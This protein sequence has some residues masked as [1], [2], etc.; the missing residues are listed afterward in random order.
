MTKDFRLGNYVHKYER[1]T[2]RGKIQCK[3]GMSEY[4]GFNTHGYELMVS[5]TMWVSHTTDFRYPQ[6]KKFLEDWVWKLFVLETVSVH[7]YPDRP[8]YPDCP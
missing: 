1:H 3:L 5:D 8:Y 7:M 4:H 2:K 6:Q